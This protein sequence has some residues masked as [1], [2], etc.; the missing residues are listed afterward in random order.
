[1]RRSALRTTGTRVFF[2]K[3]RPFGEYDRNEIILGAWSK[4]LW[5]R[6]KKVCRNN[7]R[8]LWSAIRKAIGRVPLPRWGSWRVEDDFAVL[9]ALKF[10]DVQRPSYGLDGDL[11]FW[12]TT[13]DPSVIEAAKAWRG[14]IFQS[15]ANR[16]AMQFGDSPRLI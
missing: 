11:V 14:E 6:Y 8:E 4:I 13:A 9:T 3:K 10:S 1:M 12:D 5:R 2:R 15:V 16:V 7:P